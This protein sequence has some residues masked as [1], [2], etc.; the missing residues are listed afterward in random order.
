[1][2]MT[3][4]QLHRI[5]VRI[6]EF[7]LRLFT[8]AWLEWNRSATTETCALFSLAMHDVWREAR[9]FPM[10]ATS[11]TEATLRYCV[12]CY[13]ISLLESKPSLVISD[14]MTTCHELFQPCA[15]LR[16]ERSVVSLIFYGTTIES[17]EKKMRITPGLFSPKLLQVHTRNIHH[18]KAK[19]LSFPKH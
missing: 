11:T 1:M 6:Y 8:H 18:L 5:V 13:D 4:G 17:E 15:V 9:L 10:W 3:H 7:I 12:A 19:F 14:D 2:T 16:T